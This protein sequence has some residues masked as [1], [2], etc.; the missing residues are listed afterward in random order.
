MVAP[1]TSLL[2]IAAFVGVPDL[3]NKICVSW[4]FLEFFEE[5]HCSNAHHEETTLCPT[6]SCS[7]NGSQTAKNDVAADH[8]LQPTRPC[9]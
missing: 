3:E 2:L 1:K 8:T 5:G 7:A 4:S 6:R 9:Q